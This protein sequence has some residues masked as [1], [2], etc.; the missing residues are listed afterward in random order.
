MLKKGPG[1]ESY[2]DMG[3]PKHPFPW[4]QIWDFMKHQNPNLLLGMVVN[5]YQ[6]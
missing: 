4:A 3:Y 5:I 1:D 2:I 6:S